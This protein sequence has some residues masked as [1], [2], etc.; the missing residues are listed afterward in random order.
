MLIEL[1]LL[2]QLYKHLKMLHKLAYDLMADGSAYSHSSAHMQAAALM[3]LNGM[4]CAARQCDAR[5]CA[6][7]Q[8]DARQCYAMRCKAMLCH[9]TLA[10]ADELRIYH[11]LML[12]SPIKD[13]TAVQSM[14]ENDIHA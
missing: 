7:R 3:S 14:S 1:K 6:A 12:S 10:T 9:V 4:Q 13:A 5:Q 2:L 11:L 8:R